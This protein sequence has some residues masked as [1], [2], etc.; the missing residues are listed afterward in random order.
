M[1]RFPVP[2]LALKVA[3]A[4]PPRSLVLQGGVLPG[5]TVAP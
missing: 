4:K 5:T 1:I 2:E 3:V